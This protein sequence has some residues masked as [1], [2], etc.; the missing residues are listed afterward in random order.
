MKMVIIVVIRNVNR[1]Q[2]GV[3]HSIFTGSVSG[4]M[5]AAHVGKK[6]RE[7]KTKMSKRNEGVTRRRS[8]EDEEEGR[9]SNF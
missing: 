8:V 9:K 2:G 1:I 6:E 3:F 7:R 5:I 4:V